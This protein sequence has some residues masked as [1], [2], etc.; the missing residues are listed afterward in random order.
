[1]CAPGELSSVPAPNA[2]GIVDAHTHTNRTPHDPHVEQVYIL[3]DD[4]CSIIDDDGW[5]VPVW[6]CAMEVQSARRFGWCWLG[7]RRCMSEYREV[8]C[9]MEVITCEQTG[10]RVCADGC[11][12]AVG[13]CER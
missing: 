7:L 1:M 10:E 5:L 9:A 8:Y 11:R 3:S 2:K 4:R 6:E 13:D 12:G